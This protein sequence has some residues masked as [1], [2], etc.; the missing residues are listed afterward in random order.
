MTCDVITLCALCIAILPPACQTQVIG[1]LSAYMIVAKMYI[2][3]FWILICIGTA[4]PLA[5]NDRRCI[6]ALIRGS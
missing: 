3:V 1:G 4:F 6:I 5:D 2:E